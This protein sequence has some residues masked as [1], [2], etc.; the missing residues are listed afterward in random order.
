MKAD[1]KSSLVVKYGKNELRRIRTILQPK[2]FE[3]ADGMVIVKEPI[4]VDEYLKPY[5]SDGKLIW[6]HER[7]DW[8][9]ASPAPPTR[10]RRLKKWLMQPLEPTPLPKARMMA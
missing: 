9:T 2:A 3:Q 4:E 8:D 5:F 10:W 6:H 1:R 7:Y